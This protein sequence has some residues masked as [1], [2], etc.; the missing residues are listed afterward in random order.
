MLN[1]FGGENCLAEV[2]RESAPLRLLM[3]LATTDEPKEK[4]N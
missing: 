4:A 3:K 1:L 2:R